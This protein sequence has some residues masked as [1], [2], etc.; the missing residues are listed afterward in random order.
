MARWN[1]V[2]PALVVT[3][4]LGACG[5]GTSDTPFSPSTPRYDGGGTSLGGNVTPPTGGDPEASA[6]SAPPIVT[7]EAAADST[8]RTGG[9]SLGGN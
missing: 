5:Q 1:R 9:T 2:I 8:G 7:S 4:V 3:L 6:S